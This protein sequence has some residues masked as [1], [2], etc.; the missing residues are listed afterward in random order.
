VHRDQQHVK[1]YRSIQLLADT[2]LLK[3]IFLVDITSK[4][5]QL[6]FPNSTQY[7]YKIYDNLCQ[8]V[9]FSYNVSFNYS[10][11]L[12]HFTH[13]LPSTKETE[14]VLLSNTIT[15]GL[16]LKQEKCWNNF[17]IWWQVHVWH[18]SSEI[19]QPFR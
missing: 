18:S 14:L 3:F 6:Y 10:N 12:Y 17:T 11:I 9:S 8:S 16:G 15:T 4:I 2:E 7:M 13:T 19:H 1:N 5:F